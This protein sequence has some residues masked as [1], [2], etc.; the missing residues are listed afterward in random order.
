MDDID[1]RMVCDRKACL[2]DF[3][4]VL[5]LLLRM[6]WKKLLSALDLDLQLRI[7]CGRSICSRCLE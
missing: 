6:D 4:L 3:D 7:G 1:L 2:L 5:G